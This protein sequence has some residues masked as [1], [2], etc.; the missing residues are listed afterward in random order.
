MKFTFVFILFSLSLSII[1][2][3]ND[4]T[5]GKYLTGRDW[6]VISDKFNNELTHTSYDELMFLRFNKDN[7]GI[8]NYLNES[9]EEDIIFTWEYNEGFLNLIDESGDA[10][11]EE[12]NG[13]IEF[14]D[15][16][17]MTLKIIDPEIRYIYCQERRNLRAMDIGLYEKAV[18][19][20]TAIAYQTYLD[21]MPGG[22]YVEVVK[23]SLS[24]FEWEDARKTRDI[25]KLNTFCEVFGESEYFEDVQYLIDEIRWDDCLKLHSKSGYADYINMSNRT[26]A[27]HLTEAYAEYEEFAWTDAKNANSIE[28]YTEY[29]RVYPEG[30]YSPEAKDHLKF[31]VAK[32]ENSIPAFNNYLSA[33]P[34]GRHASEAREIVANAYLF[35]GDKSYESFISEKGSAPIASANSTLAGF[36][37]EALTYYDRLIA[38]YPGNS[39]TIELKKGRYAEACFYKAELLFAGGQYTE[40]VKYYDKSI[41]ANYSGWFA[42]EANAKKNKAEKIV[43]RNNLPDLQ[44]IEYNGASTAPLGIMWGSSN[45]GR[46]G[47]WISAKISPGF[48]TGSSYY[49]YDGHQFV[50]NVMTPQATGK[51]VRSTGSVTAGLTAPLGYPFAL[52][53]GAGYYYEAMLMQVDETDDYGDYYDT[54]WIRDES[55]SISGIEAS[56]GLLMNTN[57]IS[58]SA[59]MS[60]VNFEKVIFNVGVGWTF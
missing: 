24:G 44:F 31:A 52:Y 11:D 55:R 14:L 21:K 42:S 9:D 57:D 37:D 53:G 3:V 8:S 16:T 45:I 20:N 49:T 60:L 2:Q 39:K 28:L 51:E 30:K 43:R 4:N 38:E 54:K 7:T 58:L 15:S 5:V 17:R 23:N 6:V 27:L 36:L 33:Y 18:E 56:F 50:G 48:F 47:G 29:L 1:A 12:M 32:K 26:Y 10:F 40:S 35:W 41:S 13:R 25:N 19:L 59:G 22:K 46:I 34:S